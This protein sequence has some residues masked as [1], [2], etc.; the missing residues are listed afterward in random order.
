MSIVSPEMISE[1]QL[2]GQSGEVA[3]LPALTDLEISFAA[4]EEH[5]LQVQRSFAG[6]PEL[7]T[8]ME[9]TLLEASKGCADLMYED[10]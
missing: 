2:I 10:G 7:S 1:R 4:L 5:T 9:F 8:I 6:T 3:K